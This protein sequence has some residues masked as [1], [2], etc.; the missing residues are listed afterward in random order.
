MSWPFRWFINMGMGLGRLIACFFTPNTVKPNLVLVI[1]DI[2][3]IGMYDVHAWISPGAYV[4]KRI[5]IMLSDE[6]LSV[7]DRV[8]PKGNRSR[9]ISQA[10]LHYVATRGKQTLRQR[11][12]REALENAAR[13]IELAA[14]W[15]PLEE[16]VDKRVSA[17]RPSR[18][19]HRT[20]RP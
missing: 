18:K 1:V 4:S 3:T 17:A 15:F 6:T 14:E 20:K 10:V 2:H 19:T 12:K 8:A 16:E 9:F 11:L 13:D 5:N 7:L